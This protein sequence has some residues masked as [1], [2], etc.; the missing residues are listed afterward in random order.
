MQE[1]FPLHSFPITYLIDQ[2]GLVIG[3][4]VGV[5]AWD[6]PKVLEFLRHYIRVRPPHHRLDVEAEACRATA[7]VL[8]ATRRLQR[9]GG[10]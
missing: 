9:I 4:I 2:G 6:S 10:P 3:Y 8:G 5:A 7:A 1:A